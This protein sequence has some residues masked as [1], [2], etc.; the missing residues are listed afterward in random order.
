QGTCPPQMLPEFSGWKTHS[1]SFR[2]SIVHPWLSPVQD[3]AYLSSIL[4]KLGGQLCDDTL[5]AAS[6]HRGNG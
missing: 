5:H 6:P 3:D 4:V 2:K 1:D